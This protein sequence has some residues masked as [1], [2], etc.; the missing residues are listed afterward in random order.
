VQQQHL[1]AENGD[2]WTLNYLSSSAAPKS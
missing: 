1:P 2:D